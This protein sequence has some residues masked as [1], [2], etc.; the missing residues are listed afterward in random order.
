MIKMIMYS[1]MKKT[2]KE[3]EEQVCKR[4][5]LKERRI[6]REEIQML[7]QREPKKLNEDLFQSVIKFLEFN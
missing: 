6:R 7:Q 2:K 3:K 5:R 1:K 4:K